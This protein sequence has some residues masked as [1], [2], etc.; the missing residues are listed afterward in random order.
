[1]A[2]FGTFVGGGVSR[3]DHRREMV[4]SRVSASSSSFSHSRNRGQP[5]RPSRYISIYVVLLLASAGVLFLFSQRKIA[6]VD[7][8]DQ[9]KNWYQVVSLYPRIC[10]CPCPTM[11]SLNLS[12]L[13][14][15]LFLLFLNFSSLLFGAGGRYHSIRMW[16]LVSLCRFFSS[17]HRSFGSEDVSQQFRKCNYNFNLRSSYFSHRYGSRSFTGWDVCFLLL[18]VSKAT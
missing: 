11:L 14:F 16:H 10:R 3:G 2:G 9:S 4:N 7:R 6:E 17:V 8:N 13:W 5:R 18:V 15:L 1:M 12:V